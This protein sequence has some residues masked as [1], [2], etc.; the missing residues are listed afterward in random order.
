M[1][2][3]YSTSLNPCRPEVLANLANPTCVDDWSL[4]PPADRSTVTAVATTASGTYKPA[5]QFTVGFW[6]RC[7][8]TINLVAWNMPASDTTTTAGVPLLRRATQGRASGAGSAADADRDDE[9]V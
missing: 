9:G 3:A 8:P 5:Q 1:T 4:K 6:S 7:R 2:A